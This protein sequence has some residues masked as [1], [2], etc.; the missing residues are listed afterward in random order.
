MTTTPLNENLKASW[1][2]MVNPYAEPDLRRS[3]W[4]IANTLIPYIVLWAV[5]LWSVHVSYWLTLALS[6]L[7]A[8]FMTRLFIIFHDCCHG[9]FFKS[10]KASET[11][12]VVLGVLT[13]TPY[14][15]WRHDHA[16]HHA[17]AGNLDRRGVGDVTT[18]TV[19]EYRAAPRLYRIGYRILRNPL[20]LFTIG[21][22]FMFTVIHRIPLGNPGK[23]EF[24]NIWFTNIAIAVIVIAL[25]LIAGFKTLFL[26]A[27][28]LIMLSTGAGVWLFYVQHNFEG[29]YWERKDKW[30]FLNAGLDGSSYYKLPAVLAWFTGNIGYHHIH[31]LSPKIPNY[32]LP[33][34]H[35]AN[36][37][38]QVDPLTIPKSLKSLRIRLLDEAN[39]RMVG[40]EAARQ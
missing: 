26:V 11:L 35:M 29:A 8:G 15:H 39:K 12:G 5:M 23:R 32:R 25:G 16:V 10:W 20:F 3:L 36:P 33:E 27:L 24:R 7:A 34:C 38:L 18:W 2:K 22:T 9:S 1:P 17:T 28:P 30:S 40:F 37:D 21:S 31:H 4:Q 13:L 6:V 19:E 14:Y